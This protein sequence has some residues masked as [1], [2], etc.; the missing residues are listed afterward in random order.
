MPSETLAVLVP[1]RGGGCG[2][3][4][5]EGGN[6]VSRARS[7]RRRRAFLKDFFCGGVDVIVVEEVVRSRSWVRTLDH[8]AQSSDLS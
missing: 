4:G 5:R 3:D 2:D 8:E 1:E 7:K 6:I